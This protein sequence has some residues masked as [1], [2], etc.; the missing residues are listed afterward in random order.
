MSARPLPTCCADL[1]EARKRFGRQVDHLLPFYHRTD[2]M[3][4]KVV[5][6]FAS[7]PPGV[8]RKMFETAL[9]QGIDKVRAAPRVLHDLFEQVTDVPF[10]VD[11]D[12]LDRGGAI[13]R[14]C[15][16][17]GGVILACS[18]LPLIYSSPGGNKP[19]V[20][21]GRLQN[22]AARRLSE[23]ARF[24]FE[25]TLLGGLRPGADGWKITVRVRLMHAQVRL[26]LQ[27]SDRW[28]AAAWGPPISQVDMAYTNL[29]FSVALVDNLRRVGFH[30]ST[31]EGE[32]VMQVWRYSGYL[33]GIAPELLCATEP[34]GRRLLE[35]IRSTQGPPDTDARALTDALMKRAIPGLV[36]RGRRGTEHRAPELALRCFGLSQALLG[37]PVAEALQ[38]PKT[39]WRYLACPLTR[40]LIVPIE[41][42]RRLLPG[43]HAL[44]VRYGTWRVRRRLRANPDAAH[45]S[46][47]MPVRL[48][49]VV[50]PPPALPLPPPPRPQPRA[51]E[52]AAVTDE[53]FRYLTDHD[54]QMMHKRA[55]R[56]TRHRGEV[57]LA[58]GANEHKLFLI[59][60]GYVSVE[61]ADQGRGIA[62]ARLGPGQV[63]GE[64]SLLEDTGATASVI[65]EDDVVV[66]VV[67]ESDLL[68]LLSSDP[69][70]S[71]RF[72][73]S[74]A[75]TMAH[76]LR[77]TTQA[78]WTALVHEGERNR[79]HR[80]STGQVTE[81]QIPAA[82]TAAIDTFKKTLHGVDE[83]LRDGRATGETVQAE[84]NRACDALCVTLEEFTRQEALLEIGYDD[85]M[86]FRDPAQLAQGVG[87]YVFRET[88]PLFMAS[89]T[90]ARLYMKPSGY[91]ED[92][93]TLQRIYAGEPAGD[94]RLGPFL[95][96]WF[97]SRPVCVAR[98][99]GR[100]QI[101]QTLKQ[102]A[103]GHGPLR[104]TS[105]TCGTAEELFDLVGSAAGPIYATCID[106]DPEALRIA[107]EAARERGCADRITFLRADVMDLARG[108]GRVSLGPQQIIY[109]LRLCDY[110]ID[111]QVPVLLDWV[112]DHLPDGGTLALTGLDL[113][114]S[115]RAFLEHTL[116]WHV[117]SRSEERLRDLAAKSRFRDHPPMVRRDGAGLFL[118]AHRP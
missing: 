32:A 4:D 101:A 82:L 1:A 14:R 43:G 22:R 69:G 86:S 97:L 11:W 15:G 18:S 109:G 26:L 29:L 113:A 57:L 115:D 79:F 51:E 110:L 5:A 21:S 19:L 73:Q 60:Q 41:I 39:A 118:V 71:T 80:D 78:R 28:N 52:I 90:M 85:V 38:Y 2:P 37:Q 87:G 6:A 98:R 13:H 10:W 112:F 36:L 42:C 64:M 47:P 117:H 20:F 48:V 91:P 31:E 107:S 111:E 70:F 58:Q 99:N 104:V 16:V 49:D 95:D 35:L 34:E 66:D 45:A 50:P 77:L 105:L 103:T 102:V 30:V 53:A 9:A 23:T 93:V 3:A 100:N 24:V 72:Y 63:F 88:F 33:L 114:P 25:S 76:R 44:A 68:G 116:E 40:A 84:V 8:G 96:R 55:D 62:V 75:V 61:M 65:A 74:L 92:R 12:Q 59:L 54:R 81:R 94:G 46:F 83:Q 7:L 17:T 56:V 27:R 67:K 106:S 89:S 108:Q